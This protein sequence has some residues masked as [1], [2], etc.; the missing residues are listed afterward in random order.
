MS[1]H[2][3]YSPSVFCMNF[4]ITEDNK[5]TVSRYSE[6]LGISE[7]EFLNRMISIFKDIDSN[8]LSCLLFEGVK[9]NSKM[10]K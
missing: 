1:A 8:M 7:T 10:R 5:K 3:T 4:R 6:L 9:A 2:D